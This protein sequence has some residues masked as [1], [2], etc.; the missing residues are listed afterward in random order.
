MLWLPAARERPEC[1]WHWEQ[2]AIESGMASHIEIELKWALGESG[3]G[4]LRERLRELLGP[5][6]IL[7]QLNRFFDTQDS[8]LRRQGL[9]VRLRRE[10][11]TLLMTC[12]RRLPPR[13]GAHC[14]DEWEC[15]LPMALWETLTQ[16]HL[17]RR[18]PLPEH[19]LAAL[20]GEALVAL[21]G[22]A[23]ERLEYRH[24]QEL[25]CLDRTDFGSRIDFELEIE[26]ND[27]ARSAPAWQQRLL[28]WD[29]VS[30]HQGLSKFARFLA[31]A[32][33]HAAP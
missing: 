8:R 21:G 28:G 25:L 14:H 17:E 11:A 5:P 22:F 2:P 24:A 1:C 23:N 18:L 16:P 4:H 15:Q 12:K 6:R 19:L 32:T 3:H 31:L 29:I 33:P 27:P 20:D 13:D 26:T 7:Q 30:S 10:D 9:N